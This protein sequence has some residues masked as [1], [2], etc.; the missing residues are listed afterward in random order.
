[1]WD[2]SIKVDDVSYFVD[3]QEVSTVSAAQF[4]LVDTI[5][6]YKMPLLSRFDTREDNTNLLDFL[7]GRSLRFQNFKSSVGAD[8]ISNICLDCEREPDSPEH[9]LFFCPTFEGQ[10]RATFLDEIDLEY[11]SDYKLAV[12][13]SNNQGIRKEF[14]RLVRH[15]C[16]SSIHSDCYSAERLD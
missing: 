3:K 14:R 9:K 11:A 15:I 10:D 6:T 16:R 1:M 7:H 4:E 13:F 8:V 2:K 5:I 12:C